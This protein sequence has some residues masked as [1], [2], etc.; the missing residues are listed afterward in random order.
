MSEKNKIEDFWKFVNKTDSCWLWTGGRMRSGGYGRFTL[1]GKRWRAHVLSYR[2]S[3]GKIPSGMGVLHRCDVT[4]CVN[5]DHLFLG[6][7]ADNNRD[8]HKK[9][10]TKGMFQKGNNL[11]SNHP[12]ATL[13]EEKVREIKKF[14]SLSKTK[15]TNAANIFNVSAQQIY[16]IKTGKTWGHVCLF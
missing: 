11:G 14:I 5:P 15:K 12:R 4:N 16:S 13:N 7:Q 1:E 10:R 9:G 8:R 3:K 2:T 6:T